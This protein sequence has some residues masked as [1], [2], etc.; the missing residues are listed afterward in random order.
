[1][2][3]I[4]VTDDFELGWLLAV[5]GAAVWAPR[6]IAAWIAALGSAREVVAHVKSGEPPPDG[7]EPLPREARLRLAALD[8]ESAR[9]ALDAAR[10]SGA[11]ILT[12]DDQ[13]YP[14]RLRD[15]C[16]APLV[17]Y[18]LGDATATEGRAIAIVGSRAAT[19]YGRSVSAQF[20]RDGVAHGAAIISGLA[21]GVDAAAHTS[22]VDSGGR[23][24]AVIGSGVSALYPQYHSLLADDIVAAGGA[25]FSEFPPAMKARAFHFPMRNRIVAA[26][27]DATIVTEAAS[28]SGALITARLADEFGR[29]VFAVPGDIDRP[30]SAGTNAL[31]KDGVMA[32]T[33]M[34]DV[35]DT[36]GWSASQP[37]DATPCDALVAIMQ[38]R[39][40]DVDELSEVTGLPVAELAA[41]LTLLELRGDVERRSG[42][43]YAAVARRRPKNNASR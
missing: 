21:R 39:P 10:A 18:C 31:I 38:T 12:R 4:V 24:V 5:A 27:A 17:L 23:T 42:S 8:D 13:R 41:R 26:L 25:V 1:M 15:L 19:L 3:P 35:A 11:H 40:F 9:C 34:S 2:I 33:S 28:R 14:S 32:A 36:L 37:S 6:P 22:A 30:T 7:I 20:A 16:D 29:H 43:T